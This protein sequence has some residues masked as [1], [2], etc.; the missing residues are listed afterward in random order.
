MSLLLLFQ[1][2]SSSYV[3]RIP[4]GAS[5]PAMGDVIL[6]KHGDRGRVPL[7]TGGIRASWE[8]SAAGDFSAFC[9][10]SDVL[11]H[12]DAPKDLRGWWLTWDHPYLGA[13]GGV[14]SDLALRSGGVLEI[15]AQGWL[16]LLEKRLTRRRDV[17]VI[18]HAGGI[19]AR[20]VRD[21][22]A[23]DPTGIAGT[24][25]DEWGDF[26][27]WR[28][29]GGEV[30]SA[31]S[32]LAS[33]SDQDYTV[34]ESDRVFYWRRRFGTDNRHRVQL[35]QGTHV[36][37]WRPSWSLAPVVTEVILAPSDRTRFAKAPSV[38]GHDADAYAAFGPRQQRGTM[39]GRVARSSARATAEK[40]AAKL[41]RRG[42]LID[43]DVVNVDG[44]FGWFSKGDTITV[45]LSEIDAALAV[46][47]LVLSWDQ[48]ADILRVSGEI[49]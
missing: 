48:D 46:R 13:W 25:A 6:A 49:Q 12:V 5:G 2:A 15:A 11:E 19:A 35:V 10:L 14:I 8:I 20:L 9:R 7:E 30:L 28:D 4:T 38:A 23:V 34:G 3:R 18:A 47:C 43:F 39:R 37:E 22:G 26:V 33:L 29:D 44:C 32:R 36:A 16:A 40:Q 42:Q 45:L 24:S 27:T 17:S 31:L 21:A 1:S 41:A